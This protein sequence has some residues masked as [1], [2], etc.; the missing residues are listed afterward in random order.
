MAIN[1]YEY[2]EEEIKSS[3]TNLHENEKDVPY[4]TTPD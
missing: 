2:A 4:E 1:E 3:L